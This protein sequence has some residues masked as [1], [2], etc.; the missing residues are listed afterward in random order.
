MILLI[1]IIVYAIVFGL[2]WWLVGML[3]LPSPIRM[4]VNVCFVLLL[5]VA[6]LSMVGILPG[7]H[8]PLVHLGNF[9]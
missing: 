2:L 9:R 6:L 3:P 4:I 1:S 8:F 7:E 5:I